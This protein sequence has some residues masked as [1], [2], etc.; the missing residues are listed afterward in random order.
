[1]KKLEFIQEIVEQ[2]EVMEETSTKKNAEIA[3]NAVV[4]AI[5]SALA[6]GEGIEI[7]GFG[8]F[9]IRERAAREGR[10]PRTKEAISIPATKVVG[11]KVSK[12]LSEL[13]K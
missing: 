7:Q 9:E 8:N 5:K 6:K 2:L 1:M 4:G 13:V 11:F 10:N 12:I 3:L